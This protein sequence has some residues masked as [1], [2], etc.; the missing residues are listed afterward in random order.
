M[1]FLHVEN[2]AA[3]QKAQL[4]GFLIG[5]GNGTPFEFPDQG[6]GGFNRTFS[7]LKDRAA[8]LRD[9]AAE[10]GDIQLNSLRNARRF[11]VH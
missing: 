2:R 10:A 1:S 9:A 3:G 7:D 6:T 11:R 5:N 8:I 4:S